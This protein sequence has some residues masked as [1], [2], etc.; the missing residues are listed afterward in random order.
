[1]KRESIGDITRSGGFSRVVQEVNDTKEPIVILRN[2]EPT[3]II[4][5]VD[6][7]MI[8]VMD[9]SANFGRA[10]REYVARGLNEELEMYLVSHIILGVQAK[11][12]L[13]LALTD[14]VLAELETTM[15][16]AMKNAMLETAQKTVKEL[17]D[18]A[19]KKV[20]GEDSALL[21]SNTSA[22]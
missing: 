22:P 19:F 21:E 5:P 18:D 4:M 1:M 20:H 6:K 14:S 7:G 9:E 12:I 15:V 2:S 17:Y 13:G 8:K 3:A 10:L 16:K 11:A